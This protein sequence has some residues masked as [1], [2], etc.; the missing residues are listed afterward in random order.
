[1]LSYE[2]RNGEG[3]LIARLRP[4]FEKDLFGSDEPKYF[5]PK[6]VVP[7]VYRGGRRFDWWFLV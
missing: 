2:I 3:V 7:C 4:K 1:M 6:V 5:R